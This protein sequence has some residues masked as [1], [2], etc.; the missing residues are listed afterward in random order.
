MWSIFS[1]LSVLKWKYGWRILANPL[2]REQPQKEVT[3]LQTTLE[4]LHHEVNQY[5]E[6]VQQ[7][8]SALHKNLKPWTGLTV[9]EAA[10]EE[11]ET[12]YELSSWPPEEAGGKRHGP[13]ER[14][15]A[16]RRA[17][18]WE[19]KR[20]ERA[21]ADV[22]E[23]KTELLC[24]PHENWWV[25]WWRQRATGEDPEVK[26]CPG[27]SVRTREELKNIKTEHIYKCVIPVH[28]HWWTPVIKQTLMLPYFSTF[29][30]SNLSKRFIFKCNFALNNINPG[31]DITGLKDL[32]QTINQDI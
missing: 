15:A 2:E 29:R 1:S 31:C 4:R 9:T 19:L 6:Q 12:K 13:P 25:L 5:K 22:Q 3:E 11:S 20:H 26:E 21:L 27:G 32:L 14:T 8:I 24:Q 10:L 30:V 23:K 7:L 17:F 28:L 18:H 16:K